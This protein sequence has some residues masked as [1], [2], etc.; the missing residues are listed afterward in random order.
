[1]LTFPGWNSVEG[2]SAWARAFTYAGWTSLF[3]LGIFEILAHTYTARK[4][5]LV[6]EK[7]E[8]TKGN[9]DAE[10]K[11]LRDQV[12]ASGD[13]VAKA[14]GDA[15]AARKEADEFQTKIGQANEHADEAQAELKKLK[16]DRALT[17][18]QAANIATKLKPFG[19]QTFDIITYWDSSEA[20]AISQRIA[21]ILVHLAGWEIIQPKGW[22]YPL[23]GYTGVMVYVH[24]LADDNTKG[25]ANALVTALVAEGISASMTKPR[26]G[27]DPSPKTNKISLTIGTK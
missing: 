12:K 25:A 4:E 16:E 7:A 15:T 17:D 24:P 9:D 27:S 18:E 1:M 8:A 2:A 14:T 10:I 6:A 5:T 19:A 13:A 23:G 20:V 22:S 21:G 26:G 3:L 11:R